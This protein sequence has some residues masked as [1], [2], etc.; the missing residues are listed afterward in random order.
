MIFNYKFIYRFGFFEGLYQWYKLP[1]NRNNL[2][3][4]AFIIIIMT[5]VTVVALFLVDWSFQN[6]LQYV[7][8]LVQLPFLV[9]FVVVVSWCFDTGTLN[10]KYIELILDPNSIFQILIYAINIYII[11][12][13]QI[14]PWYR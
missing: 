3:T 11:C 1:I 7:D 10:I 8:L 14:I 2:L 5:V 12:N 6:Y 9:F 13:G 4:D